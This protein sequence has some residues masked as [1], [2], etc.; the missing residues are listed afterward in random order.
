MGLS[1]ARPADRAGSS[2]AS[3]TAG[4]VLDRADAAGL[5]CAS[6]PPIGLLLACYAG[7]FDGPE[8]CLADELLRADGGPVAIVA[9]SRVTMPYGMT[10]LGSELLD[11]CFERHAPTL[12]DALLHAKRRSVEADGPSLSAARLAFDAVARAVG[13]PGADL[14]AE[15]REHLLLFNLI[16]DPL[17][18]L[19][20]PRDAT[21]TL[22]ATATAGDRLAVTG[23]TAVD[24]DCTIELVPAPDRSLWQ[25]P[26][27]QQYDPSPQAMA[28]YQTAYW[29]PTPGRLLSVGSRAANGHF[30]AEIPLP[31]GKAGHYLVRAFIAGRDDFAIGAANLEVQPPKTRALRRRPPSRPRGSNSPLGANFRVAI[32]RRGRAQTI[33][34]PAAL[35]APSSGGR[36]YR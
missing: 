18:R 12:G 22:A 25:P 15:R 31:A 33:R 4:H 14:A 29:Q 21:L 19:H 6:G 27:R 1:G 2:C 24:G 30:A 3:P 26:V 13:P 28:S 9:G 7:A 23:R 32:R 36:M 20:Y 16:G 8:R 10:M 11:E 17:L 34:W 5:H 35:L